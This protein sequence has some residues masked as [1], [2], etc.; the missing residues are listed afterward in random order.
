MK[1]NVLIVLACVLL[2]LIW[3]G[4]EKE[5]EPAGTG[6]EYV[7]GN[8]QSGYI[9][10]V[11]ED[12][13]TVRVFDQNGL[14]FEGYD[15]VFKVNSTNFG[16]LSFAG[17]VGDSLL[18][19]TDS[20]GFARVQWTL[21]DVVGTQSIAVIAT[22]LTGAPIVFSATGI[23]W[24]QDARDGK[25]YRTV[26]IGTQVWMAEN[27]DYETPSSFVNPSFPS[28]V[29]GRFYGWT[30]ANSVCPLGWHLPS[31]IEWT[32]LENTLGGNAVGSLL[33]SV[34]GWNFGNGNNL[35]GMN[36]YPAGQMNAD[37]TFSYLTAESGLWTSTD[38]SSTTALRRKLVNGS[39]G[40]TKGQLEKNYGLSCRCV[41]D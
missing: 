20:L 8:N 7:S 3:S 35:S 38:N 4:C 19:S 9:N 23:P 40:I 21:G 37:S 28:S 15:L 6:L 12:S 18:I 32:T 26:T 36:V 11:L 5:P 17:Q 39:T 1:I 41:E 31:D 27:L 16:Q 29:Y 10:L 22:G 33:K 13:L 25:Y 24:M 34:D 14:P 2:T 30:T